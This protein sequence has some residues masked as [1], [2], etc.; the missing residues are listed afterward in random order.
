M[1]SSI[2]YI[3]Q[4]HFNFHNKKIQEWYEE[5]DTNIKE[6]VEKFW[7]QY[8]DGLIEGDEDDDLNH[9]LQK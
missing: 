3:S 5:V 4:D 2:I 8:K 6:Q 9:L 1:N 7:Q